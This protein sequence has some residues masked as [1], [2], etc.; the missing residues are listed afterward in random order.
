M[1]S[2]RRADRLL[3]GLFILSWLLAG[4]V[5]TSV[6][7]GEAAGA[8]AVDSG[9]PSV[10]DAAYRGDL[11]RV[12]LLLRKGAAVDA[13]VA[14]STALMQSFQPFVGPPSPTM[15]ALPASDRRASNQRN[16]N[17]LTI[18][19]LL[20]SAGANVKRTDRNGATAL[21]S[22]MLAAGDEHALVGVVRELLRKGAVV[23]A[24]TI[25]QVTPLQLAVWKR[26]FEIAKILVAA[27]AS[28][29]ARDSQGKSAAGELVAQGSQRVLED[30]RKV[31]AASR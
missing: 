27:G 4:A 29:D 18:A 26:R 31:A 5:T 20:L 6:A 25:N 16:K 24:Q 28:L 23:D 15:G 8:T 13:D 22:A 21:H 11:Q 3:F 9:V 14:G 7:H 19:N 12:R 30:L 2:S 17:K 10:C 1:R